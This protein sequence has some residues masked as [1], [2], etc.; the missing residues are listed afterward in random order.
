MKDLFE[1]AAHHWVFSLVV[2]CWS[3][4]TV[5]IV[6]NRAFNI[7]TLIVGKEAPHD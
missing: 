5:E 7:V 3:Y 1:C 6:V 2:M 4:T